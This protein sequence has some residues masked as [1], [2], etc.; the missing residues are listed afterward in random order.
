M[1]ADFPFRLLEAPDALASCHGWSEEVY[2]D[3]LAFQLGK[4][5]QEELDAKY[6]RRQAI[7][8]LDLTGFTS[9]AMTLGARAFLRILDAQ[10]ICIPAFQ[11][12]GALLIRAFADDLVAIFDE[13]AR[14]LDAAFQVHARVAAFN[15]SSLAGSEPAECCIGIGYG[16]VYAI[17]ANLAMGDEMN[18]AAKLGEDIARGFETLVTGSVYEALRHRPDV[19]FEP[20]R[21]D[22]MLFP[23]FRAVPKP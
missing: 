15:R 16:D 2:R 20:L 10:K 13:P 6:L 4:V 1:S 14:A 9:R 18:R 3:L 17:G 5:S 12:H 21:H 22:D 23:Y 8:A 7:L 11:D 19:L